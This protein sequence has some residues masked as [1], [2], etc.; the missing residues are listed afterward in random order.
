MLDMQESVGA[1][2]LHVNARGLQIAANRRGK[3][4]LWRGLAEEPYERLGR[5]TRWQPTSGPRRRASRE[6]IPREA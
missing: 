6:A 1:C 2:R 4:E 5:H 3:R